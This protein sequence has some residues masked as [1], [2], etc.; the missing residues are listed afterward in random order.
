MQAAKAAKTAAEAKGQKRKQE[1]MMG[2]EE[3]KAPAKAKAKAKAEVKPPPLVRQYG[4]DFGS[5]D[6][7]FEKFLKEISRD[8]WPW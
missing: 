3:E 6:E 2:G 5:N 7:S 4:F 8:E 1:E